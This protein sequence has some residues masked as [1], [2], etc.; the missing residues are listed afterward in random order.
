MSTGI[1]GK[2]HLLSFLCSVLFSAQKEEHQS[3]EIIHPDNASQKVLFLNRIANS[4]IGLY[5]CNII[6]RAHT[7]LDKRNRG[8]R[9][10]YM[11]NVYENK[12]N[13]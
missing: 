13:S 3:Q 2:S 8:H 5:Y 12:S 10:Y 7:T 9:D 4:Q 6:D 1:L 11:K